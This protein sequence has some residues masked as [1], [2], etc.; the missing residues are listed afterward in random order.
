MKAL[1]EASV[2]SV[3][4]FDYK[5]PYSGDTHRHLARVVAVRKLT[6]TDI[7]RIS[8][9]SRWRKHDS[10]FKRSETIVT[11]QMPDGG[12][13]NFYGERTDNCKKSLLGW[14]LFRTGLARLV[15]HT[16]AA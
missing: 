13:R 14:L 7:H 16:K 11:C 10:D 1:S 15:F 12:F 2:G 6:E 5:Q 9:D 3:C 8:A 4:N